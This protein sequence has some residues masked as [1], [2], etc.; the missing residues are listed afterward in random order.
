MTKFTNILFDKTFKVVLWNPRNKE[1]FIDMIE[2]F[3]GKKVKDITFNDK[4]QPGLSVSDKSSIFDMFV[5]SDSG[6]KFVVE[7][8][9]SEQRGYQD[10]MLSYATH[11]IRYQLA[12]K[13]AAAATLREQGQNPSNPMDYTLTP[14]YV[15]SIANFA[16]KHSDES[17]L[18]GSGLVSRYSIRNDSNGELMTN[19]LHFIFLELGRLKVNYGEE[20]KCKSLY[21]KFAYSVKYM[22]LMDRRPEGY[23]EE[24]LKKLFYAAEYAGLTPEQQDKYDKLMTTELDIIA[25]QQFAHDKGMEEG[26]AKGEAKGENKAKRAIASELLKRGMDIKEVASVTGLTE[27]EITTKREM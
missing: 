7:V 27:Q 1:L 16:L 18:E 9:Y 4:E 3:V 6:E 22:H 24:L 5:T 12:E 10:R 8:Q 23:D 14:I 25:Q 15:I 17:A 26:L 19:A 2:F 11:P 21:E 20:D 13:M